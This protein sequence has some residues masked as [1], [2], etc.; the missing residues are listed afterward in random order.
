MDGLWIDSVI[1]ALKCSPVERLLLARICYRA[2]GNGGVCKDSNRDLG[3]AIGVHYNTI[4]E[5]VKKLNTAEFLTATVDPGKANERMLEPSEELLKAYTNNRKHYQSK[6]DS[7][8]SRQHYQEIPNSPE[9]QQSEGDYQP[10]PD[11]DDPEDSYQSNT[12]STNQTISD[13]LIGSQSNTDST[14]NDTLIGSQGLTDS[15]NK[16]EN[17]EN[18]NLMITDVLGSVLKKMQINVG[19]SSIK[20]DTQTFSKGIYFLQLINEKT[21]RIISTLKIIK[22]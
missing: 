20:I 6:A 11:S 7:K 13:A 3:T 5:L 22:I 19:T 15:Y 9:S 8:R 1:M 2:A 18:T 12:D 16:D 4:S 17:K 21:K 14:I 10:N